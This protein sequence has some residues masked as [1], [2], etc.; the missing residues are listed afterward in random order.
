MR[1]ILIGQEK[2]LRAKTRFYPRNEAHPCVGMGGIAPDNT[3]PANGNLGEQLARGEVQLNPMYS[4]ESSSDDDNDDNFNGLE[5]RQKRMRL[6]SPSREAGGAPEL[7]HNAARDSGAQGNTNDNR[8]NKRLMEIEKKLTELDEKIH[9]T[10]IHSKAIQQQYHSI[11]EREEFHSARLDRI[12]SFVRCDLIRML[13]RGPRSKLD[14]DICRDTTF[15]ES[16]ATTNGMDCS[17]AEAIEFFGSILNDTWTIDPVVLPDASVMEP[18]SGG[19]FDKFSLA[20]NVFSDL[21]DAV[22]LDYSDSRSQVALWRWALKSSK[23]IAMAPK[24][25]ASSLVVIIYPMRLRS[26]PIMSISCLQ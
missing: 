3:I 17:R 5:P 4:D 25:A 10:M 21:C 24:S 6:A 19:S 15:I 18:T 1:K 22:C 2:E 16:P 12:R 23:K 11:M 9:V 26:I 8:A 20:F 14:N 13:K 7:H